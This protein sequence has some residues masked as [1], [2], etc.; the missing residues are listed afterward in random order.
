MGASCALV[1]LFY[2]EKAVDAHGN[3][4][5]SEIVRQQSHPGA[6]P[7]QFAVGRVMTFGEDKDAVPA[8]NRFPGKRKTLAE[9]CLARERKQVEQ[10]DA[11]EPF[12]AIEHPQEQ[13]SA[14][15][16]GAQGFESF[17]AGGGC[18]F[19][20]EPRRKRCKDKPNIHIINVIRD[21][22]YR[23][24]HSAQVF[25][26]D[27]SRPPQNEYRWTQQSVMHGKTDPSYGPALDPGGIVI[28]H[29]SRRF[30]LQH[31]FQVAHRAHCGKTRLA[32]IDLIALLQRAKEFD[33]IERTQVQVRIEIRVGIQ[34]RNR[35]PGDTRNQFGQGGGALCPVHRSHKHALGRCR[36]F[37]APWFERRG[38]GEILVRPDHPAMNALVFGQSLIRRLDHASRFGSVFQNQRCHRFSIACQGKGNNDA[39]FDFRLLPERVLQI[40]GIDIHTCRSDDHIFLSAFKI[41]VSFPVEFADVTGVVPTFASGYR[42]Q[43]SSAPIIGGD[44]AAAHQNFSVRGKLDFSALEDFPDRAP[45]DSERMIDTDQRGRLGQAVPLDDGETQTRPKFFGLLIQGSPAGNKSP[46]LPTELMVKVSKN[47]PSLEKVLPFGTLVCRAKPFQFALGLE[48]TFDFLLQ[49]LHHARHGDQHGDSLLGDGGDHIGWL[50]SVLEKDRAAHERW[51]IHPEELSENMAQR[52]QIKKADGMHPALV[53]EI[54]PDLSLEGCDVREHVPVRD[55]DSLRLRRGS[56]GKDNLQRIFGAAFRREWNRRVATYDLAEILEKHGGLCNLIVFAR[57]DKKPGF[58]LSEDT[59]G[60]VGGGAIIHG[61][62]DYP[63]VCTCEEG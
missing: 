9:S 41:Q 25:A 7:A 13:I 58:D 3:D 11:G 31:S 38:A 45:A 8:I 34:F 1:R 42:A 24:F 37:R 46:K 61:D 6:K 44:A 60:K 19:V 5:N 53:F 18:E 28:N 57:T 15:R 43:F 62:D 26:P 63:A 30:S 51:Q 14:G 50:K 17:S 22:Q 20:A 47:P 36:D 35:T 10:R 29:P 56:R 40:F 2:L 27:D 33:A 4:G 55:H 12:H 52:K 48:I 49:R 59:N 54:G 16:R 23:P 39:I 21:Y 32:Q